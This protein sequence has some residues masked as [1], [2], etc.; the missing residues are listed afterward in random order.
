MITVDDVRA[1]TGVDSS[2]ISDTDIATLIDQAWIKLM[3]DITIPVVKPLSSIDNGLNYR[4][5]EAN[6]W[7]FDINNDGTI[8]YD[9]VSIYYYDNQGIAQ[10]IS[11]PF[12]Y[13]PLDKRLT[14]TSSLTT[15]NQ[16]YIEYREVYTN[17]Q[18]IIEEAH[19]WLSAY[20]LAARVWGIGPQVIRM[21]RSGWDVKAPGQIFIS[22]YNSIVR[23]I[24]PIGGSIEYDSHYSILDNSI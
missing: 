12:I 6:G 17:N 11:T 19:K 9:D 1:L 14:F 15:T 13:N 8:D 10:E 3:N 4:I 23:S 22:T 16:Y 21:G 5:L 24:T 7:I 18:S 2:E 20:L